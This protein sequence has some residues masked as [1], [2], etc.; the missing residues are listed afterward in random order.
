MRM[1]T[2]SSLSLGGS[3]RWRAGY[4]PAWPCTPSRPVG[5]PP[6]N[7]VRSAGP[8]VEISV[9]P[10]REPHSRH[11]SDAGDCGPSLPPSVES[12]E[13]TSQGNSSPRLKGSS[14]APLRRSATHTCTI[15]QAKKPRGRPSSR[16]PASTCLS[17]D[18]FAHSQSDN[19]QNVVIQVSHGGT[20]PSFIDVP[21]VR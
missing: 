11:E 14:Q 4:R 17:Q 12:S 19:Q 15:A 1:P 5:R 3:R 7:V 8:V 6:P 13:P 21:E 16:C 10:N 20:R 9:Y 18:S 2:R